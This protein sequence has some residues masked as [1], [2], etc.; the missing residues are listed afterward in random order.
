MRDAKLVLLGYPFR[1]EVSHA[2]AS[3]YHDAASHPGLIIS[4]F[5]YEYDRTTTNYYTIENTN[6]TKN[7][8]KR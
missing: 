8:K 3:L 1:D 6:T 4:A 5:T 2:R 7:T